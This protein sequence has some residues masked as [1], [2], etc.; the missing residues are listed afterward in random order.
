MSISCDNK[1][2]LETDGGDS[3]S[4]A[5]VCEEDLRNV[6]PLHSCHHT[7]IRVDMR[8]VSY[9]N[10]DSHLLLLLISYILYF[11]RD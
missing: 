11:M 5:I 3:G 4:L 6:C 1:Q 7:P 10:E 8:V 9:Y 2:W